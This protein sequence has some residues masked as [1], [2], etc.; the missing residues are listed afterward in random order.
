MSNPNSN[1]DS[2][3]SRSVRWRWCLV[4]IFA[5]SLVVGLWR[6]HRKAEK[7]EAQ[8]GPGADSLSTANVSNPQAQT[9]RNQ[10]R[11]F[12]LPDAEPALT[13]AEIVTGKVGQFGR[14][15]RELGHSIASRLQKEG[16]P[17]GENF[18]V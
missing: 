4:T 9:L 17:E 11:R 18:F 14:K 5:V 7:N 6:A 10:N 1:L 16:P 13:A 15:R 2:E 3:F 12:E 8:P